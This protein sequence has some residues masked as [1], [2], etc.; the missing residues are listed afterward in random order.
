MTDLLVLRVERPYLTE[1]ELLQSENWTITKKSVFLIGAA[2]YPEGAIVRCELALS[3]GIRLLVAE[4]MVA[5]YAA[6]TAERPAGL[7]VRYRRMTP[8][9]TQFV[10]RALSNRDAAE[11]SSPSAVHHPMVRAGDALADP[12]RTANILTKRALPRQSNGSQQETHQVL[13]RLM[14]RGRKPVE[15]PAERTT[16]LS[17]LRMRAGDLPEH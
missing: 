5:K 17:R 11:G 10:N 12:A 16:V 1:S 7:V 13:Q 2:E 15:V 6:A 8:A 9:S 4:G 3:S 14:S